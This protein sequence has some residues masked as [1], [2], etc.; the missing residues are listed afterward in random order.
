MI[1]HEV[2]SAV[3][4]S[5]KKPENKEQLSWKMEYIARKGKASNPP[6]NTNR[7]IFSTLIALMSA[8][9]IVFHTSFCLDTSALLASKNS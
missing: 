3:N 7:K 6:F 1:E 4:C 2:C 5:E 9:V 8:I